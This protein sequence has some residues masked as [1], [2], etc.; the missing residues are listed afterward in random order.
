MG[1]TKTAS[2]NR[3]DATRALD[4]CPP[5]F[6]CGFTLV[7]IVIALAIAGIAIAGIVSGYVFSCYEMEK[8]AC[9]TA[10]E[11]MAR[12]RVEQARSAKWDTLANPPV[13]ELT[14]TNFPVQVSA[15]DIPVKGNNPLYAT[16]ITTI[17][18]ASD[19]PPLRMIRVDCVWSLSPRGPF[20]NTITAYRAPDQ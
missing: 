11:C 1:H 2:S 9:A 12:Q 3:M 8:S 13:D 15:L 5:R 16:N 18:S 10:A 6:S 20:T 17:N 14:T 4:G 7:E 19:D